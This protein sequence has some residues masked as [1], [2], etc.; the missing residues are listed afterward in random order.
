MA[1][2]QTRAAALPVVN[3]M[4]VPDE[5][6]SRRDGASFT[7]LVSFAFG[8][9][10]GGSGEVPFHY[11]SNK[12]AGLMRLVCCCF[13]AREPTVNFIQASAVS[14]HCLPSIGLNDWR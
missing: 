9:F 6:A 10:G 1:R 5:A 8:Q 7:A 2:W 14:S 11:Y 13:V 3:Q 4:M 12:W